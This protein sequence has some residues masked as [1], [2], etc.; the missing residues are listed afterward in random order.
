MNSLFEH[1]NNMVR[2]ISSEAYHE[3]IQLWVC[4]CLAYRDI[5]ERTGVSVGQ[6]SQIISEKKK[7]S[8]DVDSLRELSRIIKGYFTETC[9][10]GID[11]ELKLKDVYFSI[12]HHGLPTVRM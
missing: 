1:V 4:E 12:V 11:I 8:P 10:C 9:G 3:V 2:L 6:I 7:K 5:Q